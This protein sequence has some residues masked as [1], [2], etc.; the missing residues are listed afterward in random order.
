MTEVRISRPPRSP[1][2]KKWNAGLSLLTLIGLFACNGSTDSPGGEEGTVREGTQATVTG[3]GVSEC[4]AYLT[5]YESCI[6]QVV[7]GSANQAAA[8]EG[9]HKNR[10]DWALLAS[11][12]MKKDALARMCARAQLDL[13]EN[14]CSWTPAG[15]GG[16]G[17]GGGGAGGSGGG[18]GGSGGGATCNASS[19]T[20]LGGPDTLF[21]VAGNACF[22]LN[23]DTFPRRIKLQRQTGTTA[24]LPLSFTYRQ[25]S[26]AGCATQGAVRNGAFDSSTN[27]DALTPP[28]SGT[29]AGT[30]NATC[31]VV[32]SLQGSGASQLK[33]KY[34]YQ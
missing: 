5:A 1:R 24:T 22:K 30:F 32:Y 28:A 27:P 14:S 26:G 10:A 11:D 13:A 17:S 34:W 12:A 8:L 2:Q 4:D 23:P 16:S 31:P 33:F 19:A 9:L 7:T 29:G 18:A 20:S 3:T 25:N 15:A 21:T 6:N